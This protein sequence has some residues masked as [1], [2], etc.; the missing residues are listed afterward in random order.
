MSPRNNHLDQ[1]RGNLSFAH[2]LLTHHA[3]DPVSLQWAVTAAFYRAV[4]C[5]QAQLLG[6]GVNPQDHRDRNWAIAD[7]A[8]GVPPRVQ[9]AYRALFQFSIRARY[10]FGMFSPIWIRNRIFDR[11]LKT[12]TDFVGI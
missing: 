1:A 3:T 8:N 4:H 10:R 9:S 7:P 2:Y 5:M 6:R 11:E 12:V